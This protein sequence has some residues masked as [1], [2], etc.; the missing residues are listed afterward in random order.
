MVQIACDRGSPCANCVSARLECRHSTVAPRAVNPKQRVLISAQYEQKID[1]I[2]KGIDGIQLL[3]RR[4]NLHPDVE[5][6]KDGAAFHVD[7][8]DP[9]GLLDPSPS[10]VVS[11]GEIQWD[12]SIHIID[13]VK[14]VIEDSRTKDVGAEE[15]QV[16]L[17]LKRLLNALDGPAP[18]GNLSF[19]KGNVAKQVGDLPMPPLEAT[20]AILRW[21]KARA[22]YSKMGWISRVLPLEWFADT[23]RKVYF[24]I[25]DYNEVD[26]VLA[27]G[28]LS[29][30]FSEHVVVSGLEEHRDHA[31]LCRENLYHCLS[32]LPLI[33][34]PSLEVVAA[35]ILGVSNMC[36]T[37][38]YHR[39]HQRASDDTLR[40]IQ[41]R[42]FWAVYRME[43]G[44][45]LRFSRSSNIRDA[46][47]TLPFNQYD[48]RYIRLARIQG[49]V[50][51]QLFSPTGLYHTSD[52][53]RSIMAAAFAEQLRPLIKETHREALADVEY[54][55]D[56]EPDPLRV[57]YLQCELI[58]QCSLLTLVLRA[59][60]ST[61]NPL[62]ISSDDCVATAR[63]VLDIHQQCVEGAR[64]CKN[65][66]LMASKYMNWAIVNTPF[67]PFNILFTRAVQLLDYSD[68]ARLER[69]AASLRPAGST[70]ADSS[71]HPYR[72]YELLCR[73]ARLYIDRNTVRLP[74]DSTL[75]HAAVESFDDLGFPPLELGM[76]ASLGDSSISAI[77]Q[78][79]GLGDW[80]YG[81]QQL[82]NL[83]DEDVI[84]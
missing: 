84:F 83:L 37:L 81:N 58:C 47:I 56:C 48:V 14:T 75:G 32:R 50:Y 1:D 33:L 73:A 23:C 25:D 6:P 7:R 43:K 16:I 35:L 49:Q 52:Q 77:S 45:S 76:E 26:F 40:A 63:E 22:F 9:T 38:G 17:S 72:L 54:P 69:F 82:M 34:Q 71:T 42:L 68:L 15:G 13:L 3:L 11:N 36:L 57:I 20:V 4:L 53:E 64:R 31:S 27:N 29:Y 24:A 18:M 59:V 19:P 30:V 21:S 39:V 67:V 44:L 55:E 74:E 70:Q 8:A 5:K 65:D 12:Y 2:A 79:S 28:Y 80:Y 10:V 66:P 60:P 78:M 61:S 46:E 41:D 62:S 51:D